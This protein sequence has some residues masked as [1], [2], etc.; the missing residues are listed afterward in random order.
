MDRAISKS[1]VFQKNRD[2]GQTAYP[3]GKW[4]ERLH[5]YRERNSKVIK[6]AKAL[7]MKKDPL[8]KCDVCGFSFVSRY[9]I[10]GKQ[11]IEAHHTIP[12][13]SL[14]PGDETKIEDIALVCSN[15]H[16]MIHYGEKTLNISELRNILR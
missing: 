5:K 2:D 9:G 8:L 10:R 4:K 3:E 16:S 11:F 14:S 7:R 6:K 12:L 13:V 1:S 15:C